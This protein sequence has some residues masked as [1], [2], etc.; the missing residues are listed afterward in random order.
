MDMIIT[1]TAAREIPCIAVID[2]TKALD[3]EGRSGF[4]Q[5]FE[6]IGCPPEFLICIL[7]SFHTEIKSMFSLMGLLLTHS[8]VVEDMCWHPLCL[9]YF[10]SVLLYQALGTSTQGALIS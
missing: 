8:K 1:D 3:L 4:F 7:P 9:G 2:H 10:F 6:P 5:I